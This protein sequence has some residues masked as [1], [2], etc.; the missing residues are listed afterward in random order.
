MNQLELIQS[1]I[2]EIRGQRVM[3][4][5]DLAELYQVETRVLNQAVKRNIDRFPEDFMFQ[6][7]AEEWVVISSQFV[8]TSRNKR[9]K[10]ALPLAFT[11]HGVVMLSSVLRSDIAVQTSVLITRA[12]VAMRQII[13]NSPVIMSAQLQKEMKELKEYIE[14]VF[15]DP[16]DI[17]EDTRMQIELINQVLAELQVHK[18]LSEKTRRPI[19]FILPKED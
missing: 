17:N 12:F 13:A 4:D 19:G 8:M 2:Y 14:D 5:F 10:S 16:N 18:K 15:A 1:K 7:T 3:L 11:E 6:V 9:P